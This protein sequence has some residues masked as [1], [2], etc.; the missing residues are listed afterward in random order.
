M[1]AALRYDVT[2]AFRQLRRNPGFAAIVVLTLALG[3]GA[4]TAIF[5]VV[6]SVVI[7]PL[8]YPNAAELVYIQHRVAKSDAARPWPL[9]EVT[10]WD[11]RQNT[12]ALAEI[13]AYSTGD[14]GV[15]EGAGVARRLPSVR[16]TASVLGV[17]GARAAVGRL[18][19]V[20]DDRP[21]AP[22][23][24]M[25]SYGYWQ[26]AF[27]GD[28]GVVGRTLRID[29]QPVL[30]IGVLARNFG[31]PR[32]EVDLWLPAQLNPAAAPNR[33]YYLSAVGRIASGAT[34]GD[35]QSQLERRV[36][37][38]TVRFP[39][40]FS[41]DFM[42][43][44]GFQAEAIPLRNHVLG[45]VA[46]GLWILLFSVAL[47]LLVACANVANLF[48]VRTE[49]RRR[50]LAVRAAVGVRRGRLAGH[51]IVE[52]M[53]LSLIAGV[54]AVWI[55]YASLGVLLRLAPEWLPRLAE[56]RVGVVGSIFALCTSLAAGG[57]FG[58]FPVLRV[59][60][61]LRVLLDGSHNLA[62]MPRYKRT[63]VGL[64]VGQVALA[65]V[66]VTAGALLV[67]SFFRL[68]SVQ[69]GFQ[70]TSVLTVEVALPRQQYRT[71]AATSALWR[72]LVETTQTLPG[73]SSAGAGDG[74]PILGAQFCDVLWLEG[75]ARVGGNGGA[76]SCIPIAAVT[77]GYFQALGIPVRGRA[78]TW[79]DVDA[80]S[81]AVV[82]SRTLA[83]Q[84]WPGEDPIGKGI[85]GRGPGQPGTGAR[86]YR[87]V[88]VTG[89]LHMR[90]LD[91][92]PE[93]VAFFPVQPASDRLPLWGPYVNM[94][95][96]VRTNGV[97]PSTLASAIRQTVSTLDPDVAVGKALTMEEIVSR[98]VARAT[99]ALL[100]LGLAGGL[101]VLLAAVGIYGGTAYLVECRRQE[102]GI[103]M[104]LGSSTRRIGA[105]VVT[106]SLRATAIG[107][108]LGV[109]ASL[110]LGRL[111]RALLFEISPY[112]AL[113]FAT[114]IVSLLVV[115]LAASMLPARRAAH[116]DPARALRAE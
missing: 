45:N 44:R 53:L 96:L 97:A 20:E 28:A 80:G 55:A 86:Y 103:R 73:V 87:V 99:F 24:A 18:I 111:L 58:M 3:I 38:F 12:P 71:Y 6:R 35:V 30:V 90:G 82:V 9:S 84:L 76:T 110:Q 108:S 107:V 49:A 62:T 13:G 21:G 47:V 54:L 1:L 65:V 2:Y 66:L 61:G 14:V 79:S 95:L 37:G 114:A 68:Q 59:A 100:L 78:P 8:R 17:L 4:T 70:A 32:D 92:P 23:V 116:V 41:K 48:L 40:V 52:G 74:V 57:L 72:R 25:L 42:E 67:R 51:Y 98:S 93:P 27:G 77:P 19:G 39:K 85:R 22:L 16:A 7:Q 89:D 5:S 94:T 29:G 115:A 15:A 101:A 106:E 36:A 64:M 69:P 43:E 112:D 88:G 105:M 91:Q 63:R 60:T 50:E 75:P 109:V 11:Y 113:S 26:S 81:G 104:A 56:I 31:L 46:R 83:E 102:I 34:L 10:Y 33:Y